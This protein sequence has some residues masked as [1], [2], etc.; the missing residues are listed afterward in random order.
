MNNYRAPAGR[1]M[2]TSVLLLFVFVLNACATAPSS[3]DTTEP[4][5]SAPPL[6]VEDA[7]IYR[8]VPEASELR[9]RVYRGGPLGE[10]GHNHVIVTSDIKGVVYMHPRITASGFKLKIPLHSLRVDPPAARQD[11]GAGFDSHVS[12]K[13]RAGTRKNMLGPKVLAAERFPVMTLRSIKVEGP[14][15]Y[16][17]IT[18]RVTLHGVSHDY[19]VPTAVVRRDGRLIAIGGLKLQ[20]SDFGITPFS[21]FGGA[22]QV[23]DTVSV[24]FKFVAVKKAHD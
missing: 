15:W 3:S 10:L 2:Q 13:A 23:R 1:V 9:I 12:D 11:A 4:L 7:T 22:L 21:V 14:K 6:P 18:V 24:S 19:V 8:V 5:Q 20:Q 16:P 17:R